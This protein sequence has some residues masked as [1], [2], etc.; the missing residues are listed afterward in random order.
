MHALEHINDF[1]YQIGTRFSSWLYTIARH[2]IIDYYRKLRPQPSLEEAEPLIVGETATQIVDK[3][4][5]QQR[6]SSIMQKLS[7]DDQELLTLR[8]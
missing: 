5:E 2:Q 7:L 4:I 8:L 6:V 3:K 1:N